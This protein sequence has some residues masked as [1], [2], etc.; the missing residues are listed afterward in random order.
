MSAIQEVNAASPAQPWRKLWTREEAEKLAEIFPGQR[1]EL[2]EGELINKMGQKPPHA[3]LIRILMSMLEAAYP[4][5]VRVQSSISVPDPEGTYS[6]PEPDVVLLRTA[7]PF[8]DRHPGPA[9]IALLIEVSDTTLPLDRGT[10][11][12]LYAR[13]GIEEYWHIEVTNHLACTMKT[14][15]TV[16]TLLRRSLS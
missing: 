6:E 16:R 10:K 9:D 8:L 5:R 14:S 3:G 12:A 1:Y 13:C 15:N 2:I 7:D 4:T 11:A